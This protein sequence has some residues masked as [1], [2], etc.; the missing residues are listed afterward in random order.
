MFSSKL[1]ENKTYVMLDVFLETSFP[2][3]FLDLKIT[4]Q[5]IS[6]LTVKYIGIKFIYK[7]WIHCRILTVLS[8]NVHIS[9]KKSNP[10]DCYPRYEYYENTISYCGVEVFSVMAALCSAGRT[11]VEERF[12][13]FRGVAY[14]E[15]PN[16]LNFC[17]STREVNYLIIRNNVW[18]IL[19]TISR[20]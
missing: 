7:F 2:K 13:G 6:T 15:I 11:A 3:S 9:H 16:W 8:G 1:L 20:N 18:Y 10:K 19:Y 14:E 17:L 4:R 12:P 5:V